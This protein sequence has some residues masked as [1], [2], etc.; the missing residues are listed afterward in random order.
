MPD[1]ETHSLTDRQRA[2]FASLREGLE[3]DTGRTLDEW[4]EI[5]RTCPETGQRARLAWFKAEHGLAQNRASLVLSTAFPPEIGW[6]DPAALAD[7][8]WKSPQ[9]RA[10][11]DAVKAAMA[12]LDDV[13]TGQRK[14][15]T[16]FSR[17]YQFAAARPDGDALILGL[18]VPPEAA[19]KLEPPTRASWS[20]RLKSQARIATLDDIAP[21]LP[22]IRRAWQAS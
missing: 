8:L 10:L 15:F 19:A 6:G 20:E 12:T 4:V 5:A 9:A 14:A 22:A 17:N 3:R 16:A 11:L 7:A 21:L 1:A 2:W 18:A 13:V